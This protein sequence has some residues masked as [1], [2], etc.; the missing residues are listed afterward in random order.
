[1]KWYIFDLDNT[2]IYTDSLNNESYNFALKYKGLTT[3]KTCGRVTREIILECYPYIRDEDIKE[4]IDIKR[5]YFNSNLDKTI[6]NILLEEVLKSQENHHCILWTSAEKERTWKLLKYYD[7]DS[8]FNYVIISDKKNIINDIKFICD[9]A[10][11]DLKELIIFEDNL[12]VIE[13]L[14][15]LHVKVINVN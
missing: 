8:L 13:E 9:L 7:M 3:I 11:C 1:M 14:E 4:I 15:N 10:E 6:L 5:R 12:V 2:L